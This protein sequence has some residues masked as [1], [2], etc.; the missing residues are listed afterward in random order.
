[1]RDVEKLRRHSRALDAE[2]VVV[3]R[4]RGG[5]IDRLMDEGHASVVGWVMALLAGLGWETAAEVTFAVRGERGSIDVLAWHAASR[6]LLVVEVKT[7]LTSL[8]E[9]FGVTML[10]SAWRPRS[11]PTASAGRRRRL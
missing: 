6:T 9:T 3:I 1:M 11:L 10:S 5:E 8:E 7:E 4:W 2:V